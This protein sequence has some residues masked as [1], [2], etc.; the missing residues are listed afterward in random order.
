MFSP[1]CGHLIPSNGGTRT[2]FGEASFEPGCIISHCQ[3]CRQLVPATTVSS[4]P[5]SH[6][7]VD[8][9]LTHIRPGM[10]TP[11]IY[12][13]V[14]ITVNTI[15]TDSFGDVK[16]A[17]IQNT[18]PTIQKARRSSNIMAIGS[19]RPSA[20]GWQPNRNY[21]RRV[22][23]KH[24]EKSGSTVE[25]QDNPS[26]PLIRK[27]NLKLIISHED[28]PFE[29]EAVPDTE[30]WSPSEND[31]QQKINGI[32]LTTCLGY[33]L[34]QTGLWDSLIVM[35]PDCMYDFTSSQNYISNYLKSCSLWKSH[36]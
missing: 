32:L 20:S 3:H 6:V 22:S 5:T 36:Q 33:I 29:L 31:L 30:E 8:P 10:Y 7:A 21:Q 28:T 11:I 1:I 4:Q 2:Q 13:I 15:G 24:A 25:K 19:R 27:Y 16:V 9:Q 34:Q 14:N 23:E 12:T 17:S 35:K 26:L 18:L